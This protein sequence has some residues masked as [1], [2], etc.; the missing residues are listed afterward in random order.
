MS[1]W[2]ASNLFLHGITSLLTLWIIIVSM[3]ANKETRDIFLETQR[4]E[5]ERF[6]IHRAFL[7]WYTLPPFD[8]ERVLCLVIENR[9]NADMYINRG[10]YYF[11]IEKYLK[12]EMKI[13]KTTTKGFCNSIYIQLIINNDNEKFIPYEKKTVRFQIHYYFMDSGDDH[14]A[15]G[16][17][18][19]IYVCATFENQH[20]ILGQHIVNDFKNEIIKRNKKRENDKQDKVKIYECG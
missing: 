7:S 15:D 14:E 6:I 17:S 13:N 18:N 11:S 16:N 10:H 8:T 9:K 19:M 4:V 1:E 20:F 2:Q 12:S 3:R 5:N